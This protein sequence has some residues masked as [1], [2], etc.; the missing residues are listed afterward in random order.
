MLGGQPQGTAPLPENAGDSTATT[1]CCSA[2]AATR[3][4]RTARSTAHRLVLCHRCRSPGVRSG[5][6]RN[7]RARDRETPVTDAARWRSACACSSA[8]MHLPLLQQRNGTGVV[9]IDLSRLCARAARAQTR[10]TS[11]ACIRLPPLASC[12]P[13]RRRIA[14]RANFPGLPPKT[15]APPRPLLHSPAGVTESQVGAAR[16]RWCTAR[17]PETPS[18]IT[19]RTSCL[20]DQRDAAGGLVRIGR[21]AERGR[22]HPSRASAR[23]PAPRPPRMS[24]RRA[25]ARRLA[26]RPGGAGAHGRTAASRAAT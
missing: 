4:V 12:P 8:V 20:V 11:N 15:P 7:A 19:S 21:P 1:M 2:A 13:R 9:V 18:T 23:S 22:A 25:T 26:R 10:S 3:Y 14:G 24:L 5:C 16:R 17:S 6:R